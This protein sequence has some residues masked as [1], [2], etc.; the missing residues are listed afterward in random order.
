MDGASS[1]F[2]GEPAEA[3]TKLREALRFCDEGDRET[4]IRVTGH[5]MASVIQFHLAIAE[6][7]VGRPEQA[8]RTIRSS[9]A[10]ARRVMQ[11]FS[12]AQALGNGALLNILARDYDAA[13]LLATETLVVSIR[14][15]I[16]DYVSFGTV[17]SGTA[18]AARRDPAKGASMVQDGL[19][20]LRRAGWQCFAPILLVQLAIA[21]ERS[22]AADAALRTADTALQMARASGEVVWEAEALRVRAEIRLVAKGADAAEIERDFREA[23]TLAERQGA[24]IFQLRAATSLARLAARLGKPRLGRQALSA[25]YRQFSEGFSTPDLMIAQELLREAGIDVAKDAK[26]DTD[27]PTIGDVEYWDRPI[28]VDPTAS[29]V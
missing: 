2:R 1:L 18:I 3:V 21:L 26:N 14:H 4:H 6:W 16:P 15:G 29:Q 5:E 20:R 7:L 17:L 13:D 10:I 27:R 25:V 28:I 23:M 22:G 8:A 11:P 19:E 12:L 9:V 24:K